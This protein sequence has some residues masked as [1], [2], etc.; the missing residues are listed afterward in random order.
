MR[1]ISDPIYDNK[2]R[3]WRRRKNK[4][5]QEMKGVPNTFY[6][7]TAEYSMIWTC[8]DETEISDLL[9]GSRTKIN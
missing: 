7:G 9:G 3:C 8:D 6:K 2:P 4:V 1:V 5:F